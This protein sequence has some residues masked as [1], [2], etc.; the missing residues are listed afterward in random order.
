MRMKQAVA[1][2]THL[3]QVAESQ[4]TQDVIRRYHSRLKGAGQCGSVNMQY[5][6]APLPVVWSLVRRFDRPQDYKQFLSS[7]ELRA[8]DGGVGSVREV[9]VVSGL[10]AAAST[11]RLDALDEEEHVIRFSVVGGDHR[12]RNYQSTTTLHAVDG[13]A[14]TV[15]VESYVVEVPPGN[16]A[17]ETCVFVNTIIRCNLTSLASVSEEMAAAGNS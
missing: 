10:P 16:S 7:C 8:G 17:E 6:M 11:E 2:K 5:V 15:V 4:G 3:S 1:T 9:T 14:G 13:G 12:L